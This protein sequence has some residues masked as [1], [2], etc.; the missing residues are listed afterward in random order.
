M[1]QLSGRIPLLFGTLLLV[2]LVVFGY[3]KQSA[4]DGIMWW[5]GWGILIIYM[6]WLLLEANVAITEVSKG[7]SPQD[8]GSCEAYALS[9]AACI[10]SALGFETW[11]QSPGLSIPI[12]VAL[13]LGGIGLRLYAIKTLGHFYSH[14][15]RIVDNHQIITHGPYRF[16]RHPAY[17]GM[18]LAH[19]G[20]VVLFFNPYCLVALLGLLLPAM[21]HRIKVEELY[22]YQLQGYT[23]YARQCCGLLPFIW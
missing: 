20:I 10:L 11:W 1:T 12:G 5:I 13:F 6:L 2:L 17:T 23:E 7:G 14:R 21:I 16:V 19:C 4:W 18:L 3:C 22:L 9:R 8:K 15:V